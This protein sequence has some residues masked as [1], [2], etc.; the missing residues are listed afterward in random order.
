MNKVVL[1]GTSHSIQRDKGNAQFSTFI[2]D[3]IGRYGIKSIGEEI[4]T[5]DSLASEISLEMGLDY[6]VIEPNEQERIELGIASIN[7]VKHEVFMEYDDSESPDALAECEKRM[8]SGFRAR[9]QEWLRRISKFTADPILV[10]C[11]ANHISHFATLLKES[12]F[13]VI[14]ESELWQS[15]TTIKT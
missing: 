12:D 4:D 2:R 15:S 6:Q 10:I 8:Q 7:Q 1:I 9:E 14:V 11:G 5:L 3:S 13:N